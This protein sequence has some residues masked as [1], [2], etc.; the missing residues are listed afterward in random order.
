M[1]TPD[2]RTNRQVYIDVVAGIMISWMILGHCCYFSHY[3]FPG[4]AFLS[5]Y[6]PWFFYKSGTFFTPQS[7][8]KLFRKD[9]NKYLITFAKYSCIG[10]FIWSFCGLVDGSLS[11][12]DIIEKPISSFVTKGFIQGNGPLW[13]LVSL[14]FVRQ[15]SNLL[16]RQKTSPPS[17]A[18]FSFFM[19]FILYLT[20]WYNHSWWL[21][22][23]FSGMCFF[24][25]GYWLKEIEKKRIIFQISL[26]V[27]VVVLFAS[28]VRIIHFPYLYMHA[29]MMYSGN[30]ILFYPMAL[31]GV[32]VIN[33]IISI[34]CRH[35]R[36][37]VLEFVGV[38]SMN[39]YVTHW[40]LFIVVLFVV[41]S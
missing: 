1:E 16:L 5:F 30:Y 34:L 8:S 21:G 19:A 20:G 38:N 37:K 12:K 15:C 23:F 26:A 17:W 36:L 4:L 6:M 22:N 24:I 13:F 33:N 27:Y 3:N 18:L 41:K 2:A 9:M 32:I 10:W 40:I 29:N 28:L 39:M 35:I 25:L 31:A 14:F 11:W 7:Q